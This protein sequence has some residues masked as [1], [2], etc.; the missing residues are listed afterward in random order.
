M[1]TIGETTV[2]CTVVGAKI[3][4]RRSGF[5]PPDVH[6]QEKTYAAGKIP[7]GFFKREAVRR[8]KRR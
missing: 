1:A 2:L 4:Q 6:Y 3:G 5:L 7:G 8:K